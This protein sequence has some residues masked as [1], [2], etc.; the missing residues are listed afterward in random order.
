MK[1]I[2]ESIFKMAQGVAALN[3]LSGDMTIQAV[4]T[5]NAAQNYANNANMN[6]SMGTMNNTTGSIIG[7]IFTNINM[8]TIVNIILILFV[9]MFILGLF[10]FIFSLLKTTTKNS[11]N[12]N[13]VKE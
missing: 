9:T 6:P 10:G 7:G 1:K 8:P 5:A 2:H 11:S 3:K 12:S 4:N 13:D